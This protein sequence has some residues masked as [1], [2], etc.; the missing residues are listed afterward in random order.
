MVRQN[1]NSGQTRK[2]LLQAGTRLF[3]EHGFRAVSTRDI[4]QEAGVNAALIS[5]H[6]G[7]KDGIFEEVVRACASEHV[8]ERMHQ[9]TKAQSKGQVLT[10]EDIL[11][12]YLNPLIN[13]NKW[14]NSGDYFARLH[15]V[16]VTERSDLAEDVAARAF[17]TVNLAFIDEICIRLPHL[18]REVVIWRFYAMI[19]SLLFLNTQPSP[20]G[21][22][23]ISAGKCDSS[24]PEHVLMQILP[25]VLAG[26][27]ADAPKDHVK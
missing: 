6:F 14:A 1:A 20:P 9:L 19:G 27:S 12:L 2:K 7:G 3:A 23:T 18:D 25:F 22:K 5:Y 11:R 26:L 15:A 16:M 17:N 13:K 21:L 10:L 8:A 4:A 24:N